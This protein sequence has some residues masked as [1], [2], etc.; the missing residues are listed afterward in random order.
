MN[1]DTAPGET[2]GLAYLDYFN[3]WTYMVLGTYDNTTYP[4]ANWYADIPPFD[5]GDN[6]AI[7]LYTRGVDG[8]NYGFTG[9]LTF[10]V[11]QDL[12]ATVY[13]DDDWAGTMAGADP[14]GA[15]PATN[16][17]GDA[18]TT[19]HEGITGL[20]AGG[21]LHVAAGAY[22]ESDLLINKSLNSGWC[23]GRTDDHW[24]QSDGCSPVQ[25]AD[26]RSPGDHRRCK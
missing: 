1:S 20:A 19:I 6:I 21:T 17:G 9:F 11:V 4:G 5:V 15:G 13:V 12:P 16:F 10:Y 14:D 24:P 26:Q 7:Q 3:N 8:V 25:P 18:F 22:Y 2:A 23:R